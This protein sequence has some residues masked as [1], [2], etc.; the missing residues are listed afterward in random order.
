MMLKRAKLENNSP[1]A[2]SYTFTPIAIET[3]R[4]LGSEASAFFSFQ[5]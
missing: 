3:Q 5:N 4:A 2:A 1:L